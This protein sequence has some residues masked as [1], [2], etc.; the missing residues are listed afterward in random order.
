[1]N[2]RP[3][4]ALGLLVLVLV[5]CNRLQGPSSNEIVLQ[6]REAAGGPGGR[7]L[8][9]DVTPDTTAWPDTL[10]VEVWEKGTDRWR[11]VVR[12][13]TGVPWVGMVMMI[14]GSQAWLY[15]PSRQEVTV[16][17]PDTVRLP[18]VQDVVF[19]AQELIRTADAS[20]A[21]LLGNEQL[22]GGQTYKVGLAL[23]DG[24]Q[25]TIWVDG[26]TWQARKVEFNSDA[27][28]YGS[29]VVHTFETDVDV[30]DSLFE[31]TVPE[32][33]RV[34]NLNAA[35]TPSPFPEEVRK[36]VTFIVLVPTYL[37]PGTA[38]TH[39][40]TVNGAVALTYGPMPNAFTLVQGPAVGPLP[41]LDTA[42]TVPL[43][44]GQGTLIVEE[45]QGLFLTWEENGVNISIAGPLPEAE[46]LHVAETL[47][48]SNFRGD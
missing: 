17:T 47:Q 40:T 7:H 14:N 20:R 24:G 11:M 33:T 39:A 19:S 5:A 27:L 32:G 35:Q 16:G 41:A 45:G 36:Q 29:V 43:R 6:M 2:R 4:H 46:A 48:Q 23:P 34:I 8:L 25:A 15:D 31:L 18:I 38:L 42:Q 28:G 30:S 44:G 21:Q 13:A 12:Q 3:L 9:L 22:D 37:P 1:V 26:Q 10:T